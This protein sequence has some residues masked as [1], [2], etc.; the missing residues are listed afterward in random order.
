MG[1]SHTQNPMACPTCGGSLAMVTMRWKQGA[2]LVIDPPTM[3]R[4]NCPNGCAAPPV[5][6]ATVT[7]TA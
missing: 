1:E 7:V 2:D 4:F 3:E 5:L 6:T